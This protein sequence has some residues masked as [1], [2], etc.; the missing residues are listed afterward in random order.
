[1]VWTQWRVGVSPISITK[2]NSW[3]L[4]RSFYFNLVPDYRTKVLVCKSSSFGFS[5]LLENISSRFFSSD[6]DYLSYKM[7]VTRLYLTDRWTL[8]TKMIKSLF[9]LR[10][11]LPL[12]WTDWEFS[13]TMSAW[14][15]QKNPYPILLMVDFLHNQSVS[16]PNRKTPRS[17][18]T[19]EILNSYVSSWEIYVEKFRH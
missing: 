14:L 17:H 3:Y 2:H 1:M 12:L 9:L 19:K 7:R 10:E 11:S 15:L 16:G 5:I 6:Q 8:M 13:V 18:S 4:E